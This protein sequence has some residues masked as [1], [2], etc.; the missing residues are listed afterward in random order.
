MLWTDLSQESQIRIINYIKGESLVGDPLPSKEELYAAAQE[1]QMWAH[2]PTY[3][4]YE[5]EDTFPYIAKAQSIE[6]EE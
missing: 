2:L 6:F 4:H 5:A 3:T 1:L